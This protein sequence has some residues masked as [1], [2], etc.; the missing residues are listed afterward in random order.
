VREVG[1]VLVLEPQQG[2]GPAYVQSAEM[3]GWWQFLYPVAVSVC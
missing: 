2:V 1:G 3:P